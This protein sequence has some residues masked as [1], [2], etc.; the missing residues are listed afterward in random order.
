MSEC[1]PVLLTVNHVM[2]VDLS[3]SVLCD[4][5]MSLLS[6]MVRRFRYEL[7]CKLSYVGCHCL[8]KEQHCDELGEGD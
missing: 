6:Q 5:Q 1:L 3:L 8:L 4:S 2:V 7:D